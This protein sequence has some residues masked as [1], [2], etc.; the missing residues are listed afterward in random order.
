MNQVLWGLWD[1]PNYDMTHYNNLLIE[2]D[3]FNK[4]KED[5][6]NPYL[7]EEE[8]EP[9]IYFSG[10]PSKDQLT[11]RQFTDWFEEHYHPEDNP[12]RNE[13]DSCDEFY[14]LTEGEAKAW[15]DKMPDQYPEIT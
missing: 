4:Q 14:A 12:K 10:C 3:K 8:E 6:D 7:E 15:L 1:N 5:W 9:K 11:A 2:I 13:E